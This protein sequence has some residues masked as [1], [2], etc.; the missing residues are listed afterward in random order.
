MPKRTRRV[1][2]TTL[3]EVRMMR[4]R[5]EVEAK[6]VHRSLRYHPIL[7]LCGN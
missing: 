5:A 4:Y 3:E 7:N 2:A 6:G 1:Q